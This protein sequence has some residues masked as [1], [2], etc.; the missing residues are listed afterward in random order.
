[1][2]PQDRGVVV[3]LVARE[4]RNTTY[5]SMIFGGVNSYPIS[6]RFPAKSLCRKHM[7]WSRLGRSIRAE[8]KQDKYEQNSFPTL[9]P[10]LLSAT[11]AHFA[12]VGSG[13][14]EPND[15]D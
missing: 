12:A 2:L 8:M 1:M 15:V 7:E 13:V 14:P 9:Y 11:G 5:V 10:R 6:Q 4:R 3:V